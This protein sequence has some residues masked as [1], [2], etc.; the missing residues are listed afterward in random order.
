MS[1]SPVTHW[2]SAHNI[3]SAHEAATNEFIKNLTNIHSRK[4]AGFVNAKAVGVQ[5][6]SGDKGG[7]TLITKKAAAVQKPSSVNTTTFKGNKSVRK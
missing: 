7:V 2:Y 3:P 5:P 6:A 4:N 1:S